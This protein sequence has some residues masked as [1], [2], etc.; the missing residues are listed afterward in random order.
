MPSTESESDSEDC[1]VTADNEE[2]EETVLDGERECD[3]VGS[4]ETDGDSDMLLVK[5]S[6]ERDEDAVPVDVREML[7]KENVEEN[8]VVSEKV[9]DLGRDGDRWLRE[10]VCI[11]ERDTRRSDADWE[12]VTVR[13]L[14]F[15][16]VHESV[17][18]VSS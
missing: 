5:G 12:A 17:S 11:S 15:D 8:P 7:S 1:I 4:K 18:D 16:A 9:N 3:S 14:P 13:V 2:E 6:A 10:K